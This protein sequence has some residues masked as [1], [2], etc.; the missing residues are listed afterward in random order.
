MSESDLSS[1]AEHVSSMDRAALKRELLPEFEE[2][3]VMAESMAGALL[4][5]HEEDEA[6][7]K[8]HQTLLYLGDVVEA[9]VRSEQPLDIRRIEGSLNL[10]KRSQAT[11]QESSP[12]AGVAD[13]CRELAG[14]VYVSQ[15][16]NLARAG[17]YFAAANEHDP[18]IPRAETAFKIQAE[19]A[20]TLE[21]EVAPLIKQVA[22]G[23]DD[24]DTAVWSVL[25]KAEQLNGYDEDL[26][27][28]IRRHLQE[29][30][31][32]SEGTDRQRYLAGKLAREVVEASRQLRY[33]GEALGRLL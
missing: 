23:E 7:R 25:K 24:I 4:T 15:Q 19:I 30:M 31:M 5:P 3:S 9:H 8:R 13:S 11:V 26:L 33:A 14:V 27:L 1:H 21:E 16:N 17:Q 2:L 32:V 29:A 12:Q 22:R 20:A 28:S 10:L 6:R 18:A